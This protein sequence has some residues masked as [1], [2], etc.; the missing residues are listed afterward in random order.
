[1]SYAQQAIRIMDAYSGTVRGH[2]NSNARLQAGWVGSVW[3]RAGELVRHVDFDGIGSRGGWTNAGIERF[4]GMLRDVYLPLTVNGSDYNVGNW[5]LGKFDP[6]A[7][8]TDCEI[9]EWDEMR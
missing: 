2:N 8:L 5:E 6:L 4:E 9:L 7:S 1:M 3:A